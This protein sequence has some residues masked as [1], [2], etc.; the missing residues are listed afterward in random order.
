MLIYD[1][2]KLLSI[3]KLFS[4]AVNVH[5][6]LVGVQCGIGDHFNSHNSLLVGV[7]RKDDVKRQS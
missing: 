1:K 7:S 6:R 5:S 4:N 3:T 2:R